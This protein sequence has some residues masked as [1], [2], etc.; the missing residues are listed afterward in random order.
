MSVKKHKRKAV[1]HNHYEKK[2]AASLLSRYPRL[3]ILLGMVLVTLSIV[4]LTVG[5][6]S[7]ARVGLAMLS[8]FFGV[9][10]MIFANFSLPKS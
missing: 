7:N 8:L 5:Y 1:K 6:V 3:F 9:G 4:L 10:M 2:K